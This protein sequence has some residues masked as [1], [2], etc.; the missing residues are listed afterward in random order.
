ME[1]KDTD[2][3]AGTSA[4]EWE[5]I[6]MQSP[7][8]RADHRRGMIHCRS[9]GRVWTVNGLKGSFRQTLWRPSLCRSRLISSTALGTIQLS[10]GEE[11]SKAEMQ[12]S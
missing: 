4:D 3:Q 6:T 8:R 2:A 12:Y 11:A 5:T 10:E 9:G 1:I 7:G